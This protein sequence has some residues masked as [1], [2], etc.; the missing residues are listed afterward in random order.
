MHL[1]IAAVGRLK[2]GPERDLADHY[3]S[4]IEAA[5]RSHALGP[6][7]I[8]ELTEGRAATASLR[9]TGEASRLLG[10]IAKADALVVLDETG[11]PLASRG[12]A[13]F[14]RVRRDSGC[15]K[16]AF[17][18]GGP[19]GHAQDIKRGAGLV[20]SLGAMTLPHGLARIILLEQIYRA[21]TIIGGHPYHRD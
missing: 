5:G 7:E 14:L 2:Q 8:L 12:F 17:A 1:L 10:A 21:V 6:L 19:D 15:A 4:R 11:K 13:E 20:L 18:I 16:L 3:A 9:K